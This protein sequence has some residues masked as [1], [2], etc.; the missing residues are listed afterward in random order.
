MD[1]LLGSGFASWVG[2]GLGLRSGTPRRGSVRVR[3]AGY[4][5]QFSDNSPLLRSVTIRLGLYPEQRKMQD[6]KMTDQMARP[7][8]AGPKNTGLQNDGPEHLRAVM[9][10]VQEHTHTLKPLSQL[11][12][13]KQH[14]TCK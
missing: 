3:N 1:Q 4:E 12:Y 13:K 8:T 2:V 11:Q 5:C 9:S 10:L 6:R 14:A 7:E